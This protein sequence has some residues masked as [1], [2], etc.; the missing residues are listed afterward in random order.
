MFELRDEYKKYSKDLNMGSTAE[1]FDE[2]KLLNNLDKFKTIDW[3]GTTKCPGLVHI[4]IWRKV[5]GCSEEFFPTGGDDT[6]FAVKL[7]KA[8]IRIFKGLGCS[9]VYHFGSITTRKKDKNL[10][11]DLGSKANKIF[12]RKWGIS[13]NFFEKFYLNS[14]I[15]KNKKLIVREYDGPL[16]KPIKNINYYIELFVIKLKLIYLGITKS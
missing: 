10:N 11:T 5:G 3:Q 13:V 12:I 16:D 9:F 1:L 15:D 4:D 14:G 7:W 8:N 2:S 6:D